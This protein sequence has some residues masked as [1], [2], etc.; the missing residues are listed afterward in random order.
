VQKG[1]PVSLAVDVYDPE[2]AGINDARVTARVRAP[3]GKVES[4]PMD[5]TVERDGEYMARFTP[6]EDGVHV[7]EVTGDRAG[8][9]IGLASA[10]VLVAPSE[11]EYFDAAMRAPLLRRLAQE[12]NGR[13]FRASEAAGLP[14]A[15]S[16]SGRGITVVEEKEL[17]DMP[18]TLILLLGLMGAEW[19]FRRNR[20]LA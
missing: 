17:W 3:S 20:G 13:F 5:W 16:Y 15:I 10:S 12:T 2:Y 7:I 4:V 8:E 11:A 6:S 9:S 14:E 18:V 1:D 19:M